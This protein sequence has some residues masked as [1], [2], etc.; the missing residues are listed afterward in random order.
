GGGG[1]R[2]AGGKF[3][4]FWGGTTPATSLARGSSF[5]VAGA[6]VGRKG[7]GG[8][9]FSVRRT[10]DWGGRRGR[11]FDARGA[12]RGG[13]G[14]WRGARA[15][16]ASHVR[17]CASFNCAPRNSASGASTRQ[18]STAEWIWGRSCWRSS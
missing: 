15:R 8:G 18:R 7:A 16:W 3:L 9:V 1:R 17:S 11:V 13:G 5:T 6:L 4:R 2:G 12:R 14:G 10:T